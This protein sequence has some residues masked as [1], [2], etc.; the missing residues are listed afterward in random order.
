MLNISRAAFDITFF[1]YLPVLGFQPVVI[2][3]M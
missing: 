2:E 3:E 1:F